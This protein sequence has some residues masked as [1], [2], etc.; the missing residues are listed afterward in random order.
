[1]LSQLEPFGRPGKALKPEHHFSNVSRVVK[2]QTSISAYYW[3]NDQGC[4][5]NEDICNAK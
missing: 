2:Q 1:V 3:K 5:G 4:S